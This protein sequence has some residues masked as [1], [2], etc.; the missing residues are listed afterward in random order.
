[1]GKLL[2]MSD[3]FVPEAVDALLPTVRDRADDGRKTAVTGPPGAGLHAL[4]RRLEER[5]AVVIETTEMS[6]ADAS[7]RLAT[8]LARAAGAEVSAET[9]LPNLVEN[10]VER[11]RS[12]QVPLLV[13]L[14]PRTWAR[15]LTASATDSERHGFGE[16]ARK[17][18]DVLIGQKRLPV[19][20]LGVT[21]RALGLSQGDDLP[22]VRASAPGGWLQQPE[23][24]GEL[25]DV[26]ADL[27]RFVAPTHEVDPLRL[28]LAVGVVALG[29]R[30]PKA[31]GRELQINRPL[32]T[33]VEDIARAAAEHGEE[34]R[35]ALERLSLLRVALPREKL[36]EAT[37]VPKDW[38]PIL[39]H[40][41][42]YGNALVRTSDQVRRFLAKSL[43]EA[44]QRERR[45]PEA[46]ARLHAELADTHTALDGELNPNQIAF[47]SIT[48]W[49][50]KVH[51]LAAGGP[52]TRDAWLQQEELRPEML[53]DR[54]RTLSRVYRDY[55]GAAELYQ[56][57]VELDPDDDYAWHYLGFNLDRSG[58]RGALTERAYA[59]ALSKS[60]ANPWWNSRFIVHLIEQGRFRDAER[61]WSEAQREVMNLGTERPELALHL[62][63]W[64]MKAWLDAGEIKRARAVLEDVPSEAWSAE[65]SDELRKL[66]V[67]L[68]EAEEALELGATVRPPNLPMK[69][70]E[71]WRPLT[72][73]PEKGR[74]A[75]YPGRVEGVGQG[76]E[77]VLVANPE[78][79]ERR[80]ALRS[81]LSRR[82][83]DDA[84]KVPP[85]AG[86]F[87]EVGDYG[88]HRVILPL[89][90]VEALPGLIRSEELRH[91]RSWSD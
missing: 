26:A 4:A 55:E 17:L 8:E 9:P 65:R 38:A 37:K 21:A 58:R 62:H 35:T 59:T 66:E 34:A 29:L 60:P 48:H 82:V 31:M 83:W 54:A 69:A 3:A 78:D 32:E 36:L 43:R 44:E 64:V 42:G 33:L 13:V 89:P 50:E 47:G 57:C 10:A 39:T 18:L 46:S 6:Y 45:P 81:T 90:K 76:V 49:C 15:D 25:C 11:L 1:M 28:R 72:P 85:E 70:L 79:A 14:L 84:C 40:C 7:G 27:G 71:R 52:L 41:L 53:W 67:R 2:R 77:V 91:L 75:W 73:L 51:H 19:A 24:W 22:L 61:A 16:R 68:I 20:F 88:D 30:P 23:R 80:R 86:L 74:Y 63:R 12:R 87:I 56:R 5:G